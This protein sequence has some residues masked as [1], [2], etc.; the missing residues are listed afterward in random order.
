MYQPKSGIDLP[1]VFVVLVLS[2]MQIFREG[3]CQICKR[4]RVKYLVSKTQTRTLATCTTKA[5]ESA[6]KEAD[7]TKDE[8]LYHQIVVMDL[9]AKEFKYHSIF[10]NN[11]KQS[12]RIHISEH[13]KW[14]KSCFNESV[15]IVTQQRTSSGPTLPSQAER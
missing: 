6:I 10:Y 15:S 1:V 11:F 9:I 7:R 14:S 3:I 13:I 4:G 5:A 12:C 2:P 8:E